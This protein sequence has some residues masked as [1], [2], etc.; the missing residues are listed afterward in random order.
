[1][2]VGLTKDLGLAAQVAGHGNLTMLRRH[3]L[4]KIRRREAEKFF[5]RPPTIRVPP[6]IYVHPKTFELPNQAEAA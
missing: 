5:Q 2:L 6:I 1:M 3:Y 4:G